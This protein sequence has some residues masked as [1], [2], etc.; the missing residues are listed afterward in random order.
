MNCSGCGGTMA[1]IGIEG[2]MIDRCGR[3]GGVWLDS[4]EADDLAKKAP[5]S[6]KDALKA[7]KYELMRQWKVAPQD[8]RPTDRSCPRCDAHLTRVNYK[9]VPGLLVDKCP[10]DCGMYLDAGEMAKI[11]LIGD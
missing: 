5:K 6:P 8:P 3:C 4:G 11:T 1:E 9:S 7:K 2:V 10:D